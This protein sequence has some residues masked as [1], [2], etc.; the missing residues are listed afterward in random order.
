[1]L[2]GSVALNSCA[3]GVFDFTVHPKTSLFISSYILVNGYFIYCISLVH[4]PGLYFVFTHLLV[5]V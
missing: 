3:E 4:A 2:L 1:M 5:F